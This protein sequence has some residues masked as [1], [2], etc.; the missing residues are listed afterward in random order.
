VKEIL[1]LIPESLKAS[2]PALILLVVCAYLLKVFLER[3]MEGIAGRVEEIAKTSLGLKR[4][5]RG[6]EREGLV[7]LRVAV[8]R[9]AYFLENVVFD[10][11]MTAPS[12]ANVASLYGRDQEKF[13]EVRIAIVKACTYLRRKE[14]EQQLMSAVIGIR[15]SYYPIINQALP[16]LIE[17]QARLLPLEIKL[18]QF[19]Q[20]GLRD[21]SQ[22]P[23]E[24]DRRE[25]L[26]LQTEM[27]SEMQKFAEGFLRQYR[28]VAEQ[29]HELKEAINEYIYRP[30]TSSAVDED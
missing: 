11:T 19:A 27:T 13:L 2:T 25:N 17:I 5:L 7:E 30:V 23:T 29:M 18:K 10:F 15:K 12:Q 1:D 3:R 24:E 16:H 14:L 26:R 8:E 28:S 21:M 4:D 20:G 6:E 22:A 9:W